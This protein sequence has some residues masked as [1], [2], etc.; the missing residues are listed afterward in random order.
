MHRKEDCDNTLPCNSKKK[1]K[2]LEDGKKATGPNN[3]KG[4][5]Y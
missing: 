1:G 2:S 3:I 4:E 5:L